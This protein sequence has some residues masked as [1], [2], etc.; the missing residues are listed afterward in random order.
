M[1]IILSG[2]PACGKSTVGPI[3]AKKLGYSFADTDAYVTARY[4]SIT[5]IFKKYG[6]ER[7]RTFERAAVKSLLNSR[8]TVIA[9]GGGSLEDGEN[10]R[11]L[12]SCGKI[13]YLETSIDELLRRLKGDSRPLLL[14]DARSALNTLYEKRK[15]IYVESCDIVVITDGLA[16][17]E[18]AQKILEKLK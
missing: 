2:M 13:V 14:Q 16:P 9:T 11:I 12:K 10:V 5:E 8:N 18:V 4:G 17:E 3:L 1:N 6:E 7:F 15:K